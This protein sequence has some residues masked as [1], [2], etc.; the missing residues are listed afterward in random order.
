MDT[1]KKALPLVSVF[2]TFCFVF[3]LFGLLFTSIQKVNAVDFTPRLEQPAYSNKYYYDSDYNL[4]QRYGYGLPNCTAYAYGRAYEILGREPNLSTGSAYMW[5]GYNVQT[6]AYPYGQT[7]KVGAIACWTYGSGG[8]V[9]VVEKIENGIITLSNSAWGGKTF[10]ITTASLSDPVVGGNSWWTFQGYI[11]L[12]DSAETTTTTTPPSEQPSQQ[13]VQKYVT[14]TYKITKAN[15]LNVRN[16]SDLSGAIIGSAYSG[17]EYDISSTSGSWGKISSS[18]NKNGW[19][20]LDYCSL[21]GTPPIVEETQPTTEAP[22][23]PTTV[24]PTQTVVTEPTQPE[25]K[26]SVATTEEITPGYYKVSVSSDSWLNL[27]SEPK[28]DDNIV[29]QLKNNDLIA[30]NDSECKVFD[31]I[32][33]CSVV[34]KDSNNKKY[35]GWVSKEYL[36]Y[37]SELIAEVPVV[38]DPIDKT[39]IIGDANGDGELKINDAALIQM[40]ISK[41]HIMNEND[42]KYCDVDGNGK[43]D[44]NDASKIQR[45]LA[46]I[47]N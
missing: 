9:A 4:F 36:L 41:T 5:Y 29:I 8:H 19:I 18:K 26:E 2:L 27:R 17:E 47:D 31:G 7:P 30:V 12:I 20:C 28:I 22:T 37:E 23:Q 13:I 34:F 11:Y 14:G 15:V 21:V 1:Q 45:I 25:Q 35:S 43:I 39:R 6:G 40:H 32:V 38:E 10:Y 44:I 46:A 3:S 33:W 16:S 42:L 24:E